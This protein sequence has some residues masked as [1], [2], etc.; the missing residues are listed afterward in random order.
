MQSLMLKSSSLKK[1][2]WI[3]TT[4]KDI[5]N[6]LASLGRF[7]SFDCSF[8]FAVH[9]VKDGLNKTEAL[10]YLIRNGFAHGGFRI[11]EYNSEAYYVFESRDKGKLKGRAILKESTL[12]NW[13]KIVK[14]GHRC[15][16]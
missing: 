14:R 10:F 13:M 4:V 11:S 15:Q 9:T 1:D 5:K 16:L 12:R 8:E 3:K 2:N 6:E 7:E